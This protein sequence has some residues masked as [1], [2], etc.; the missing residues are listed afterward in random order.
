MG[1]NL[2]AESKALIIEDSKTSTAI[3]ADIFANSELD[4]EFV[5]NAESAQEKLLQEDIPYSLIIVSSMALLGETEYFALNLRTHAYYAHTPLVLV[6][7]QN[8]EADKNYYAVGYTQIFSRTEIGK[9]K[10]YVEQFFSR[11]V[12]GKYS[13]NTVVII[14]DDLPQRLVMA[15]ILEDLYCECVCFS[16][17]E[18]AL[19]SAHNVSAD[20]IIVDFFL[21]GKL[22]GMEFIHEIR[23]FDHVWNRIPVLAT[24]A[25]DD[26]ARKYEFLRAGA[27]DYLVKPIEPLDLN[28][29]VENL[30]RYKRLLDTVEKQREEMYYLAMHDQLTGLHNRHFIV[31]QAVGRIKEAKR[32]GIPYSI[33]L[34]DIDHFKK[35]NDTWGHDRGDDVLKAVAKVLK[36]Q[37]RTEDIVA[38]L[39]GEEFIVFIGYCDLGN[40]GKKAELLRDAIEKEEPEGLRIT[41]SFGVAELSGKN[42]NFDLLFKAADNAVYSAKSS[43]RNRVVLDEKAACSE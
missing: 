19:S 42:E 29:R 23:Q 1:V 7:T 26:P 25:L 9:L 35:V 8:S 33:I 12:Y 39:G 28:V 6:V 37:F 22:T 41:A 36:A 2:V 4:A 11:G 18:E 10:S 32:H 30:I 5:L 15:A 38:R 17:A 34:L 16:S 24:T 21:E 40:A 3:L 31:S 43:G 14:E 27:N 20:T 13:D